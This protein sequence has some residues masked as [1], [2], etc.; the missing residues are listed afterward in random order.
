M[1][2]YVIYINHKKYSINMYA[3]DFYLWLESNFGRRTAHPKFSLTRVWTH[4]L[5]IITEHFTSPKH[6][7]PLSQ[8]GTPYNEKMNW[9]DVTQ[10]LSFKTYGGTYQ[11]LPLP[12]AKQLIYQC[13]GFTCRLSCRFCLVKE[14]IVGDVSGE[15]ND[16][17]LKVLVSAVD[18]QRHF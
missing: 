2:S 4:D 6:F 16:L 15:A 11:R 18:A 9:L 5:W 8:S 1:F 14:T 12:R 10:R 7:M 3:V 17:T 13:E